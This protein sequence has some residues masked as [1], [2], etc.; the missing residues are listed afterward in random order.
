[1]SVMPVAV[2]RT[3]SGFTISRDPTLPSDFHPYGASD[4]T[5]TSIAAQHRLASPHLKRRHPHSRSNIFLSRNVPVALQSSPSTMADSDADKK[6]NKLGYRRISVACSMY[7]PHVHSSPS[8]AASDVFCSTDSTTS[9]LP[10]AQDP[11]SP[12]RRRPS[13][14]MP[15]L[16]STQKR[17][18]V[19]PGRLSTSLREWR[20]RPR[21]GRTRHDWLVHSLFFLPKNHV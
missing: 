9:A 8:C 2:P 15:D 13:R 4:A 11:V 21:N 16:H 7:L 18:R 14:S 3:M 17:V 19:Q 5:S 20:A 1:M 12:T 10:T 6:R